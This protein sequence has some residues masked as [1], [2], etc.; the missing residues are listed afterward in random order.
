MKIILLQDNYIEDL[1]DFNKEEVKF[2]KLI[3]LRVDNNKFKK[4]DKELKKAIKK[5][6]KKLIYKN[7]DT[8]SFNKKYDVNL[9]RNDVRLD[10]SDKK[11]K[12]ILTDLFQLID[13][14][15]N[16]KCLYL[17]NNNIDNAS[18]LSNIPLYHLEVLDLS[19]NYITS[20]LFLRKL[21]K[22]YTELKEL[23]LN[24]NK[25]TDITPFK[26][27][28][29]KK[30]SISFKSLKKLT[31]K[32]N[33]FYT[34]FEE[35]SNNDNNN[36]ENKNDNKSKKDKDENNKKSNDKKNKSNNKGKI[37]SIKDKDSRDVFTAIL[38]KYT[39]DFREDIKIKE[40]E[41]EKEKE[42]KEKEEKEKKEKE[43]EEKEKKEKEKKEKNKKKK[44]KKKSETKKENENDLISINSDTKSKDNVNNDNFN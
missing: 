26:D 39:T 41:E 13:F 14:Q 6:G 42:K 7:L 40:I 38:E 18:I 10:L 4:N 28:S 20:L 3:Y 15:F 1:K 43:K 32:N 11:D 19:L 25:I 21:S 33:L 17:D 37:I 5:F 36:K 9:T 23:Y 22:K 27:Y 35:K 31:L 34:D 8:K 29:N 44:K 16:I 24:D 30:I 12:E 2:E